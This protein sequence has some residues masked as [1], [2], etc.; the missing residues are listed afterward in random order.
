MPAPCRFLF[1][2]LVAGLPV[3][4]LG[5]DDPQG[6]EA[7]KAEAARVE[8]AKKA[9]A[10]AAAAQA[11]LQAQVARQNLLAQQVVLQRGIQPQ[12][13]FAVPGM[14]GAYLYAPAAEASETH[15]KLGPGEVEVRFGDDSIMRVV[16]LAEVLD[17]D[18][19]YGKLTIPLS[20]VKRVDFGLRITPEEEKIIAGAIADAGGPDPKLRVAA[21]GVLVGLREKALPAVRRAAAAAAGTEA[22]TFLADCE[23]RIKS[24]LPDG[25]SSPSDRDKVVTAGST[26]VGRLTTP[27]FKVRTYAFGEQPLKLATVRSLRT[28]SADEADDGPVTPWPGTMAPFAGQPGKVFRVRVTGQAGGGLWGTGTYTMDSYLPAAAIHAGALKPGETGVVKFKIV[29]SPQVYQGS[30]QNGLTSGN[31]PFYQGGAYEILK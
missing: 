6:E 19:A 12:P 5:G 4:A 15:L 2:V 7:K 23:G 31:Y 25:L 13:G 26:F 21:R 16:L 24:A 1:V 17:L 3:L 29:P 8:A 9:E 18:T 22:G 14:G 30:T 20:D 27:E 10:E 28:R 11:V